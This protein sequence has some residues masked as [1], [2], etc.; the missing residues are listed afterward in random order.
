MTHQ[1]GVGPV[2]IETLAV[3]VSG[4]RTC[5]AEDARR[6][7]VVPQASAAV[8]LWQLH[9]ARDRIREHL[10]RIH[11]RSGARVDM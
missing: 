10:A 2:E 4:N 6:R 1:R 8:L 11:H 3:D 5:F 9:I 7:R